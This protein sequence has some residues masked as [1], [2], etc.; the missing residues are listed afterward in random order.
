MCNHVTTTHPM[1]GGYSTS[2]CVRSG[3]YTSA[4]V[5]SGYYTSAC[6]MWRVKVGVQAFKNK[7]HTHIPLDYARIEF[8]FY[9]KIKNKN[10]KER[11][12]L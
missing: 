4:C 7:L 1:H 11:E 2:A 3:Y 10:K 12:N 8:L 5:R 6:G 9:I